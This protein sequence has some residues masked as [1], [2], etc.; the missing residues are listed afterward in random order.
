LKEK[1]IIRNFG[2]IRDVELELGRFNVLIG[3]QAT[4]KSTVAK[5]LAV[6]RYFS[7]IANDVW[8]FDEGLKDWGLKEA[9]KPNSY[10]FYECKHYTFS[11]ERVQTDISE[12]D[13]GSV[14]DLFNINLRPLSNDFAFLVK[15]LHRMQG[16]TSFFIS[17][18]SIIPTSFFQ[19]EVA[20]V[21]DNPFYFPAERGLQSLF[22]LGNN[23]RLSNSLFQQLAEI[24]ESMRLFKSE[25]KI[26]PLDITYKFADGRSWIKKATDKDFF[27]LLNAA[28]GYQT[29]IPI[30]LVV[31]YY[32]EIRKKKKTF[33]VEEPELNLFP[34]AQNKLIKYLVEQSVNCNNSLFLT[35]HSPY[36]LTSLSSLIY[37]YKLGQSHG[38]EVEKIV[39]KENWL[40]PDEFSAYKLLPDGT[41]E[42]IF[43]IESGLIKADKIDGVSEILNE[44]FDALLKIEFEE[45]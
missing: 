33:I 34:T 5:L 37:A 45:K 9:I 40:N 28:K 22:S 36:V 10:I 26:E 13:L 12:G 1:L 42:N 38:G 31:K 23:P 2:P 16:D 32:N 43:D 4:G 15:E 41:R 30:V 20:R 24:N 18:Q 19:N 44:Q 14:H 21:M 17:G 27:E 6:C 25:T 7:Y 3:E 29:A 35:T 39:P 8:A 11:A